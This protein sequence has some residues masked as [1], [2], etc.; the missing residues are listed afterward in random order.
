MKDNN[1]LYKKLNSLIKS[2][3]SKNT[4]FALVLIAIMVYCL[5]LYPLWNKVPMHDIQ[6]NLK[7]MGELSS[8]SHC[9]LIIGI[10]VGA[11]YYNRQLN[12]KSN[13]VSFYHYSSTDDTI[14][15]DTSFINKYSEILNRD[16]VRKINLKTFFV[17]DYQ[18]NTNILTY[19]DNKIEKEQIKTNPNSVE[20]TSAPIK[21]SRS[22]SSTAEGSCFCAYS[23]H[24]STPG[25]MNFSTSLMNERPGYFNN[26]DISQSNYNLKFKSHNIMCSSIKYNFLGSV[27]FSDMYPRPDKTTIHSIE[28]TDSSSIAEI[29]QKGLRFH[30]DFIDLEEMASTRIFV[31]TAF[32]SLVVSLF[33]TILYNLFTQERK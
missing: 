23:R 13:C 19:S 24:I 29:M 17:M 15:I 27:K 31:L 4:F 5:H 11:D 1:K 10:D 21:V 25:E 22:E 7:A 20:Y 8:N 2:K 18:Y 6:L 16:S 9:D 32:L 3:N 12:N 33:A 28:F 26:W 14:N 30:V